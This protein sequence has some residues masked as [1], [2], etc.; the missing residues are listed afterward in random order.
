MSTGSLKQFRLKPSIF[1]EVDEY[2][3]VERQKWLKFHEDN[4]LNWEDC[5]TLTEN[6]YRDKKTKE[7][8]AEADKFKVIKNTTRVISNEF[9]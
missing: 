7:L 4:H 6:D 2:D 9:G 1:K 5:I 3:E 8:C